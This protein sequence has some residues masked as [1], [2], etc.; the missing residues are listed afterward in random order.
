M[1]VQSWCSSSQLACLARLGL[2][3][4]AEASPAACRL[5]VCLLGSSLYTVVDEGVDGLQSGSAGTRIRLMWWH[6]EC[7]G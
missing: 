6:S 4:N 2:C 3:G 5:L 1:Q 7:C